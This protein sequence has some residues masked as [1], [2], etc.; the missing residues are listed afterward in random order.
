MSTRRKKQEN[1]K[2]LL[3]PCAESRA[4]AQR[5][6]NSNFLKPLGH[7]LKAEDYS[8]IFL[9]PYKRQISM[10]CFIALRGVRAHKNV[11]HL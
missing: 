9:Y 8:L 11:A 4:V 6:S 2:L 7:V 1:L 5:N 3:E 10:L